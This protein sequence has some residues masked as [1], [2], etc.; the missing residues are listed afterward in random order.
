MSLANTSSLECLRKNQMEEEEEEPCLLNLH[1]TAWSEAV[2]AISFW[3]DMVWVYWALLIAFQ[4]LKY[5]V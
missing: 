1:Q 5:T 2:M 4:Y 3:Y